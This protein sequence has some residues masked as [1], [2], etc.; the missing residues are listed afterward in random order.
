MQGTA[1]HACE[2]GPTYR[3]ILTAHQA[4]PALRLLSRSALWWIHLPSTH[5]A[6]LL[7]NRILFTQLM[8]T[9]KGNVFILI[10]R[11]ARGFF[12]YSHTLCPFIMLNDGRSWKESFKKEHMLFLCQL[13]L[14]SQSRS[15]IPVQYVGHGSLL[16]PLGGRTTI[17]KPAFYWLWKETCGICLVSQK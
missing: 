11:S 14:V 12:R 8:A 10:T 16:F 3:L 6:I 4:F 17:Y 5:H 2:L 1:L 9:R 15:P 13:P 7:R